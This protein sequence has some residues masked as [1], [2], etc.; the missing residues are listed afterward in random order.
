MQKCILVLILLSLLLSCNK[1]IEVKNLTLYNGVTELVEVNGNNIAFLMNLKNYNNIIALG[2]I[3]TLGDILRIYPI[4]KYLNVDVNRDFLK[5]LKYEKYLLLIYESR[6]NEII[7][8][9]FTG[10]NPYAKYSY[11]RDKN[12]YGS[13]FHV[14]NSSESTYIRSSLI[15]NSREHKSYKYN[16][17]IL[18]E[19]FKE[20]SKGIIDLGEFYPT[21]MTLFNSNVYYV[22]D[23]TLY[24]K[25]IADRL[26]ISVYKFDSEVIEIKAVKNN[27]IILLV[28]RV[29]IVDASGEVIKGF[30]LLQNGSLYSAQSIINVIDKSIVVNLKS[31]TDNI[32]KIFTIFG[33]QTGEYKVPHRTSGDSLLSKDQYLIY[34]T[35]NHLY[36]KN[37]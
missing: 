16:Y 18:D 1:V 3:N 22:V 24:K 30:N 36:L 11:L 9:S 13:I 6:G 4:D 19:Y 5:L 31:D 32:Y 10:L 20:L 27:L 17:F 33:S 28:D 7:I 35:K 21:H 23:R 14:G 25:S 29:F 15:Y 12:S 8:E 34:S 26:E 2:Y 37:L